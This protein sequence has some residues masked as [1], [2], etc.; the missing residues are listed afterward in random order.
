MGNKRFAPLC[1]LQ[2]LKLNVLCNCYIPILR[3]DQHQYIPYHLPQPSR[4]RTDVSAALIAINR[5]VFVHCVV[6][7][8]IN[9]LP[10]C[11]TYWLQ[12]YANHKLVSAASCFYRSK[13]LKNFIQLGFLL[14][15][16]VTTRMQEKLANK[17]HVWAKLSL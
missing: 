16:R 15:L 4:T 17:V 5:L 9:L 10:E 2:P 1:K 11:C 7:T 3:A 12:W 14:T 13:F 6:A 8:I